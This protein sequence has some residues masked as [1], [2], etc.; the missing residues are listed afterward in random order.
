MNNT[1]NDLPI[2]LY[3]E[4][5]NYQSYKFFSPH[6]EGKNWVFRVWAPNAKAIHLVGDF[7]HWQTG[8]DKFELISDGIWECVT[9]KPKKFDAYKLC[10]FK[11]DGSK[12]L[13]CD[14]YAIHAETAPQNASKVYE[15]DK[16]NWSDDEWIEKRDNTNSFEAPMNIYEL[17]FGSWKQ[18]PDGNY[19]SYKDMAKELIPYVKKMGYTH[20]EILPM[21]EYPFDG[22]WGYQVTGFFAPTSRYGLPKDF[23]FFVDKCH[24][25]GIG[26]DRKSVV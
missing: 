23:M 3:H 25:E 2:Y 19:L 1:Q 12:V 4:G 20:I 18:Y 17:H 13:K 14:P 11:K 24:K 8:E 16:Y 7:N 6:K 15:L 10:V 9:A 5:K 22:S 26:V 21:T